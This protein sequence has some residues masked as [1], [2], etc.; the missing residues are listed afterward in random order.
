[1]QFITFTLILSLLSIHILYTV[2]LFSFMYF[3]HLLIQKK[4]FFLSILFSSCDK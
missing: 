4:L 3:I 2:L 1:M